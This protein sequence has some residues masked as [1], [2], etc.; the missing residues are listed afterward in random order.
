MWHPFE[1]NLPQTLGGRRVAGRPGRAIPSLRPGVPTHTPS[2]GSLGIFCPSDPP[3]L[4]PGPKALSPSTEKSQC[5]SM[6]D[7]LLT[8]ADRGPSP[9]K[10]P[11]WPRAGPS[12]LVRNFETRIFLRVN[13][14]LRVKIFLR[15]KFFL[16]DHSQTRAEG[17]LSPGNWPLCQPDPSTISPS[18]I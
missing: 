13:F 5:S 1:E 12:T 7:F 2:V 11:V 10:W 15:V 4:R 18:P 6:V 16:R 14:F 8:R 3:S 17:V 9:E